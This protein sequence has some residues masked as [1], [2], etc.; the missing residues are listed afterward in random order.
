MREPGD[1]TVSVS[2]TIISAIFG[3]A[4]TIFVFW[5][6]FDFPAEWVIPT[7]LALA[8]FWLSWALLALLRTGIF[9]SGRRGWTSKTGLRRP[10]N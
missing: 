9:L 3:A 8:V 4:I 6:N 2:Q 10:K 7:K 5:P 1:Q